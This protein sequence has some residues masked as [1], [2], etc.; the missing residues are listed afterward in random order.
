MEEV[1]LEPLC[2]KLAKD[3]DRLFALE[4]ANR[5]L[6]EVQKGL[7]AYLEK[8][9]LFFPR[10]FFLSNDE[11]LEILSETKDPTRVQPHL[12]KCFEG[13][14][15]LRFEGSVV[16]GMQS[17]EKEIVPFKTPINTAQAKGAVE[18][19]LVEVEARMFE[20]VHDVTAR[21]IQSFP[22]FPR[23]EWVLEW[24]GMVV[25]VVT[26]IYWTRNVE[27]AMMKEGAG[28]GGSVSAFAQQCTKDL[29]KVV[30]QAHRWSRPRGGAGTHC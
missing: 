6:E 22:A 24:P 10:F 15:R 7:A 4:E 8:K 2:T 9:R 30:Q 28:E 23:H 29:M 26:A 18:R 17:V 19:W 16:K 3:A 27:A 13:I 21:G 20:A 1:Q 25:L 5:L 12:R 11:M 14:H